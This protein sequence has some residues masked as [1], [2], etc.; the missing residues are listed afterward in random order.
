MGVDGVIVDLVED[1]T[2]AVSEFSNWIEESEG[3]LMEDNIQHKMQPNCFQ[4]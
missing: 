1:I 2:A 3:N 4:Q